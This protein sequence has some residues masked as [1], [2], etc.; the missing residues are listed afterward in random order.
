M[1][2]QVHLLKKVNENRGTLPYHCKKQVQGRTIALCTK[3]ARVVRGWLEKANCKKPAT[4][5]LQKRL[6]TE[7]KKL[8]WCNLQVQ[9]RTITGF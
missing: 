2:R 1:S 3:F 9:R 7:R 5:R 4:Q 6:L 8:K